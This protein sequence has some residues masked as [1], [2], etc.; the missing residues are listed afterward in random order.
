MEIILGTDVAYRD[1]FS[2]FLNSHGIT[3]T[4]GNDADDY[5]NGV[6]VR[7]YEDWRGEGYQ[8]PE[9]DIFQ[10]RWIDCCKQKI[11]SLPDGIQ[12]V[13]FTYRRCQPGENNEL[14]N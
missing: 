9:R 7:P 4:L 8:N 1:E 3:A 5:V 14:C 13:N 6:R 10:S 11:N 12:Y 2:E